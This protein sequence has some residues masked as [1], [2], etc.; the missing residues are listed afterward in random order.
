M[1]ASPMF[2]NFHHPV[3]DMKNFEYTGP[4]KYYQR[5]AR[6]VKYFF[7]DF[8]IA[9][10]YESLDPPP[11]EDLVLGGNKSLPEYRL[12]ID[13]C[14]PFPTDIYYLG[15]LFATTFIEVRFPTLQ[16]IL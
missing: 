1:D 2:P 7:I 13:P 4:A 3:K 9:R 16:S 15:S 12:K 14:N 6:P 8:G 11:L 10:R 5:T